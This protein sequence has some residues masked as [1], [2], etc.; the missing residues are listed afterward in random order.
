MTTLPRL[1]GVVVAWCW[2]T[3]YFAAGNASSDMPYTLRL[4]TSL[5]LGLQ[6]ESVKALHC[7]CLHTPVYP[8]ATLLLHR[9][10]VSVLH[11]EHT[12]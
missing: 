8:E 11:A 5:L 1:G 3:Q 6:Q 9:R 10:Q 2:C 7:L 12:S 4:K